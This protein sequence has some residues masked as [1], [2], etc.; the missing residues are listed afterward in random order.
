MRRQVLR[1]SLGAWWMAV[2]AL[3][4]ASAALIVPTLSSTTSAGATCLA[5]GAL[6][7]LAG[8]AWGL[9]VVVPSHLT[10]FARLWPALT[11]THGPEHLSHQGGLDAGAIAVVLVTA[12]PALVLA[13]ILLPQIIRHLFGHAPPRRQSF[14]VAAAAMLMLGALVLPAL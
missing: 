3:G 10:L 8:H 14:Y 11:T 2:P 6:A 12:L 7:L 1:V 4:G 5:V 9:F 13:G